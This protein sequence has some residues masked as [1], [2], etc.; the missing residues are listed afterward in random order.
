MPTRKKSDLRLLLGLTGIP[1]AAGKEQRV[2][3]YIEKWIR[4]RKNLR[5]QR[6][7]WGNLLIAHGGFRKNAAAAPVLITAHL[8]HPAFVVRRLL[9]EKT[10]ELEFRGGVRDECFIGK[11]IEV[12]D[13][14]DRPHIARIK[15]LDKTKPDRIVR[16]HLHRKAPSLAPGDVGRWRLKGRGAVP[17]VV[18]DLLYAPA[19]DDLVGVAAALA[20]LD[21]LHRRNNM[22]HVGVLLTRAEEIWFIGAIGAATS[23]IIPAKARLICL[24][25]SRSFADSPI[26]AGPI[27]R[28]GDRIGVFSPHLTNLLSAILRDEEKGR[29]QFRWQRKLMPGGACEATAFAELGYESTCVCL[30]LGNYHNMT[31]MSLPEGAKTTGG[32]GPEFISVSDYYGLI[33]LLR[34]C[35]EGMV[36]GPPPLR[37]ALEKRFEERK[38]VLGAGQG[39]RI[40]S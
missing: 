40:K 2:I 33:E 1:T 22:A 8:D 15:E 31:D 13:Q 24:E 11:Q 28:V 3:A 16:A 14:S 17:V 6:D 38:G 12:F 18:K 37:A 25:N 26:G 21:A 9:D 23:G 34:I 35:I 27:L 19:C 36:T 30:P 5:L 39:S 20:A 29:P 4:R 32:I 10:V 7:R